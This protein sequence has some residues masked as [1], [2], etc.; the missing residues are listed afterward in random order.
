MKDVKHKMIEFHSPD[1]LLDSL[2]IGSE[3]LDLELSQVCN[4]DQSTLR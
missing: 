3:N 4:S 2:H 1:D